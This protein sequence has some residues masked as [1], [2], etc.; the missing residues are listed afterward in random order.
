MR[1]KNTI[2]WL[3]VVLLLAVAVFGFTNAQAIYDWL[4]LRGY[5]PSARIAGLADDTTMKDTARRVFYVNHPELDGK[6]E[7]NTHCKAQEQTIVLGCFINGDGIYLL[8][9][10][11]PRLSGVVEVTAAHEVL[12]AM[13]ERLGSKERR[14][15]DK[16]TA[17]FF[18]TLDNERIKKTIENYRAMDPGVVP[19]ELHSILGTEVRNLNPELENHYKKYF[20]DRSK[21]VDYSEDYEQTFIDIGNKAKAYER[22]LAD[23]K[24]TITSNEAVLD[25]KNTEINERQQ[26]L[27]RL[28][29]EDR[30]EEYNSQVSPYNNAID[31]YNVLVN[32]TKQLINR[33]NELIKERNELV[34][35]Q[36][37]LYQAMD[38]NSI[39]EKAIR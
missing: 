10:T 27:N 2:S 15:V 28:L 14:E 17:D 20:N 33:Y 5:E 7:F 32:E 18:R 13:Y 22:Q 8:D 34:I 39:N 30:I 31:E 12:H 26:E 21:I 38:S 29:A 16:M 11:D 3:I 9:V 36:Q 25:A 24:Q 4:H 35:Q 1:I 23:L 6:Q 19:T 37:E